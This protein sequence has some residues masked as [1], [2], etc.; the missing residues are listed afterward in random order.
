MKCHNESRFSLQL[1]DSTTLSWETR[2]KGF[3]ICFVIGVLC[4]I[5]GSLFLI[6]PKGMALFAVFYTLGNIITIVR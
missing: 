3:I 6:L 1:S 4:T 5:A 2:I